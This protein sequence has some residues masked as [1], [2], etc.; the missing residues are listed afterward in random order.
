[1]RCNSTATLAAS[2]LRGCVLTLMV[3][4]KF[5]ICSL[6]SLLTGALFSFHFSLLVFFSFFLLLLFILIFTRL[7]FAAPHD[8][9][10]RG[11]DLIY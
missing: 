2:G 8:I 11:H 3:V 9:D 6:M 4:V 1:M 10:T 7:L 5:M